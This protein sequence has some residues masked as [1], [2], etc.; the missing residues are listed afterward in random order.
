MLA[1]AAGAQS[2]LPVPKYEEAAPVEAEVRLPAYPEERTLL[3]F[4]TS[5]TTHQIAL[6]E[7]ALAVGNDG[8]VR[9]TLVVK[10]A[11]GAENVSHEG[12][13]CETGERRVYA[14]GRRGAAGGVWSAARNAAWLPIHD[15]GIN[16]YYFEFW[17]DVFC[18]GKLAETKKTIVDN[19]RAGG[20]TRS[21]GN[22]SD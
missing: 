22:P 7:A 17:R 21:Q 1:G 3:R 9:F 18:D 16:R 4:P 14:Y 5:W 19:L 20:R 8:V 11:S 12:I 15:R 6:D 13:R 10:S 2:N